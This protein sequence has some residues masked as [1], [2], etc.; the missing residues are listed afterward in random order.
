M[1]T[2]PPEHRWLFKEPFGTIFSDFSLVIPL[3]K[4]K[5]FCT[6][7]DV[8]THNA[9]SAGLIPEIGIIDGFTKRSPYLDM[10]EIRGHI[11]HVENPA[12]T[13]TDE[14]RSALR[15]ARELMPCVVIVKGEEDLAVLPLVEIMPDETIIIYGQP[16]EGLVLCEVSEQLRQDAQKLL[17]YFVST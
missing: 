8:V 16:G 2:L 15:E 1:L 14:L 7:G 12:G 10:P 6:V 4:G 3:L 9:F 17:S 11:L 5:N 13:I